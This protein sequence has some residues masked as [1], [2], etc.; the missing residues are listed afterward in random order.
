MKLET[1]GLNK[2][3]DKF[4]VGIHQ[5]SNDLSLYVTLEGNLRSRNNDST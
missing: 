5:R 1:N 2:L 4:L 3:Q